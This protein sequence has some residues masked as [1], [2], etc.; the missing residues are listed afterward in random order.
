MK[1][2]GRV[3]RRSANAVERQWNREEWRHI[4]T[5]TRRKGGGSTTCVAPVADVA[6]GEKHQSPTP[7]N[8]SRN[9]IHASDSFES[10]T[11]EIGLWWSELWLAD[12]ADMQGRP[13]SQTTSLRRGLGSWPTTRRACEGT[14]ECGIAAQPHVANLECT[15]WRRLWQGE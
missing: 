12:C 7:T 15:Q 3:G 6:R 5:P 10:A 14:V 2:R 13:S 11:K 8:T 9:L 1:S 4:R